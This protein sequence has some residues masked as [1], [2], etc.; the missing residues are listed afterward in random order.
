MLF[1][2]QWH[3]RWGSSNVMYASM[4]ELTLKTIVRSN[5]GLLLMNEGTIQAKWSSRNLPTITELDGLIAQLQLGEN[6][7]SSNNYL[8][9]LL[10]VCIIFVI[11]LIGIKWYDRRSI[12]R[13][14]KD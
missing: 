1:R 13:Q 6:T 8:A 7:T 3:D 12:N 11:P 14:M 4:D 2:S 9:R 5:P 10:I